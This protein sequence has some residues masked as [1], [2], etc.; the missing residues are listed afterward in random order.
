MV[1]TLVLGILVAIAMFSYNKIVKDSATSAC[2]ANLRQINIAMTRF[3]VE[4]NTE[5][6][7]LPD[8]DGVYSYIRG[9][10]PRC[11]AGGDYILEPWGSVPA[12]RCAKEAEGHTLQQ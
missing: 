7:A 10:R 4:N 6:G 1:V 5:V 11:P 2:R 8:A 12:V 9:E 3:A